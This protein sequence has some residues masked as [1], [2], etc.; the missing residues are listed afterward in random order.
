MGVLQRLNG[1]MTF[2]LSLL[3]L[4][5]GLSKVS[6]RIS[7][8]VY[9]FH[10]SFFQ[11]AHALWQYRVF[12]HIMLQTSPMQ[13]QSIVG[14]SETILA[15]IMGLMSSMRRKAAFGLALIM[16]GAVITHNW[17]EEDFS[18]PGTLLFSC[19]FISMTHSRV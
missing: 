13:F 17:L 4:A 3:F 14:W 2:V 10:K 7:P 18:L 6:D 9:I 5:A 15:L 19:L 16:V 8:D 12:D 11:Q 1:I